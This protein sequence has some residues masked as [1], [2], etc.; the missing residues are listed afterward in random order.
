MR[1]N[2]R[3]EMGMSYLEHT[4]GLKGRRVLVTGAG[5]GIGRAIAVA[6]AGAGAEVLVHYHASKEPA[7]ELVKQ[8]GGNAWSVQAD[9]TQP[10]Q[11][12]EMSTRIK[13]RW[14]R[15]DCVVNNA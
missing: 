2:A 5:R 4:F 9:L 10:Q 11:V 13:E 14:D 12:E 7:E 3:Y 6:L 8:L 1:T 15:L